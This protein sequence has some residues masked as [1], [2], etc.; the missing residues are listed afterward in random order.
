[1]VA[2]YVVREV[3]SSSPYNFVGD[4]GQTVFLVAYELKV[5]GPQTDGF[6]PMTMTATQNRKTNSPAP[7]PGDELF[8]DVRKT[9]RGYKLKSAAKRD[10]DRTPFDGASKAGY[11]QQDPPEVIAR[12]T[13]SHAQKVAVEVY[14]AM[15]TDGLLGKPADAQAFFG[16]VGRICDWLAADVKRAAEAAE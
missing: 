1:M 10:Q 8:V 6:D 11:R 3:L 16:E 12:I 2:T 4:E 5:D 7:E 14:T 15:R 13:R 9:K